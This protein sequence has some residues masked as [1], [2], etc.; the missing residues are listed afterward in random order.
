[1]SGLV[2]GKVLPGGRSIAIGGPNNLLPDTPQNIITSGS[3]NKSIAIIVGTTSEDGSY[4]AT[5]AYDILATSNKLN[6]KY[7][8][9]HDLVKTL[10]RMSGTNYYQ[11]SFTTTF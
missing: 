10:C 4:V 11:C 1:M 7:F 3:Y 8:M 2:E 6:D 5:V 9:T